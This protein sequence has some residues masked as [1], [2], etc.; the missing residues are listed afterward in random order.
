[1][2]DELSLDIPLAEDVSILAEPVSVGSFTTPN[3]LAVHPMEGCDGDSRGRPGLLTERRYLRFARGGAGLIWAEATAVVPEGRANPRQLWLNDESVEAIGRLVQETRAAAAER[4]GEAHRPL[5]V[6]QLTHSGRYSRPGPQRHPLIPAHDPYRDARM[7]LPDDWPVLTDD[8]LD[9]LPDAY[10]RAAVMAFDAGFDAVD[11]KACHGYLFN[12]VLG[13]HTRPGKYGGS[14]EN[15]VRLMLDT[16]D[17][18]RAAVGPDRMITSRLGVYDAVAHPYGWAVDRDDPARPDLSEPLR[19]IQMLVER[20]VGLLNVTMGNPY[21]E[22]HV[23]R[24]FDQPVVGGYAP[25]EHPLVGVA[26]M[27]GLASQIQR[28]FPSLAVVGTGYSWLR[29]LM[30]YV[31]AGAKASGM[32]TFAGAG[33]MAF[34]YPDFAADIVRAGRLD[35]ERV[36]INCSACTQIMRDGGTTGC[37]VRDAE[38]YGP[39]YARGRLG[40]RDYLAQLAGACRGCNDPTCRQACP[41]GIE[42]PQFI[43]LFLE[44]KEQEAYEVI[45]R[46]NVFPET[47]AYLCPVET[48]CQGHCLENFLGT[49]VPIAAVQRYLAEKANSEG[50]SRIRVPVEAS[51]RRVAVVGAGP[52]GLACAAVL[53]EAGHRVVVF[54]REDRLGGMINRAIPADRVGDSLAREIAALFDQVPEDRFAFRP[55]VGLDEQF[56]VDHLFDQGFDAVFLGMGLPGALAATSQRLEGLT[57]G[58]AFLEA[59]KEPGAAGL[60]GRRV[61]VVGGGNT[62]MDAAVTAKRLGAED[63]YLV[64]RRSFAEM[65]AWP[66]ERDRAL[67]AGVHFLILNDVAGYVDQNGR[68]TGVRLCPTELGEPDASG[69]RRPV[70][71]PDQAYTLKMDLVVE[72]IGQAPPAELREALPGVELCDGRIARRPASCQ[73][74]RDRVFVGGDIQHGAATVVAAVADGMRAARE[75]CATVLAR[76]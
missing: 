32:V 38:V 27:I 24:P 18:V 26:R 4:F 50:W 28:A 72:A 39:I 74:T 65:P 6:A 3:S 16:V 36:C 10:A 20:G 12:E 14:F 53:L 22:P 68:L 57:D 5:V 47:C 71:L 54:D 67:T 25:P 73:T 8:D 23:N 64:Y 37:V 7:N 45:R 76:D 29:G 35:P 59:A 60:R 52:A 34:A 75:M 2:A 63:V 13:C 17:R 44:G 1:M 41:A 40:N 31:A 62:A 55:R 58:L 49:A 69:R 61:A 70:A 66:K 33:R 15:R 21:Y 51:G 46:S 43:R 48:Q 56:T 19:L 30:P 11:I 42:I 9:R